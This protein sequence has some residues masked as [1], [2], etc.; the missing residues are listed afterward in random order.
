VTVT[1]RRTASS[2]HTDTQSS[3][4][5][6]CVASARRSES[7]GLKKDSQR[8]LGDTFQRHSAVNPNHNPLLEFT[9]WHCTQ[10]EQ[11]TPCTSHCQRLHPLSAL[12]PSRFSYIFPTAASLWMESGFLT[13]THSESKEL[14][15]RLSRPE[16]T[17]TVLSFRKQ[18]FSP[19][20]A[21]Y[22]RH[23]RLQ[24]LPV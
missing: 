13:R 3:A 16:S 7:T 14:H 19:K 10:T 15:T 18:F 17:Q 22:T 4:P 9:Q 8:H 23:G 2:S 20:P 1:T 21:N 5:P 11:R 12:T 6:L 24:R